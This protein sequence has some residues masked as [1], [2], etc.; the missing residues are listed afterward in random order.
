MMKRNF[1]KY[2]VSILV[3]IS[4][5]TNVSAS[6]L[7][8]LTPQEAN[9]YQDI[10]NNLENQYG[11]TQVDDMIG[12]MTGFCMAKLIDFNGDDKP[13]LYCAAKVGEG[14][15][16]HQW[17]YGFDHGNLFSNSIDSMTNLGTD[18]SP[19]SIFY[20]GDDQSYI[21]IGN[22]VINGN[23]ISF[24]TLNGT[25]LVPVLRFRHS[26]ADAYGGIYEINGVPTTSDAVMQAIDDFTY[27]L[28]EEIYDYYYDPYTYTHTKLATT[29]NETRALL[30]SLTNP[31]AMRSDSSLILDGVP[32]T[33][34]AYNINGNNYFKLRDLAAILNGTQKQ[35]EVTW[36][37]TNSC[38]NL[39]SNSPYTFAG[40]ELDTSSSSDQNAVFN[41]S[42]I[43]LNGHE[44]ALTA[45]TIHDHTY[46]KLRDVAS[47]L[48]FGVTWD[49]GKNAIGIDT[50]CGYTD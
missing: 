32:V 47:I 13:E 3:G 2:L 45:Y 39:L 22:D 42:S 14:V 44:I 15:W 4:C 18:V 38:I 41:D 23:E 10:I 9:V 48:D 5:I 33:V 7:G 8:S 16:Y 40:G 43:Y 27:G 31:T 11:S 17:I 34:S 19:Q 25:Q 24:C 6:D 46:F 20:I 49:A 28:E 37:G 50:S 36:D 29:T 1:K 35:F 26:L 30:W 12:V 21:M